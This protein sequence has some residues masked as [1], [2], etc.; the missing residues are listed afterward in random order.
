MS[1]GIESIET[2]WP[3][4]STDITIIVSVRYVLRP[5][6]ASTPM[7]STLIR[8]ASGV[9]EGDGSIGAAEAGVRKLGSGSGVK[10]GAAATGAGSTKISFAASRAACVTAPA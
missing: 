9:G 1:R 3:S 7:T 10:S 5:T 4:G 6:P 8:E 2:V